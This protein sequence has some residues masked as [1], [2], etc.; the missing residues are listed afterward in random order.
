MKYVIT[1]ATSFIGIELTNY[2]IGQGYEVYAVCRK[3]S[4]HA[5]TIPNKAKIV[6]SE[7]AEYG[8][9]YDKIEAADVFVNFAW[10]GTGH[11]GRNV[12]DIQK[13]NIQN[14]IGAI[15]SAHQMGCKL[16]VEAGSQA[17]YGTVTNEITEETPCNPFSEYGKAK[18]EVKK[19]AV[20]LCKQLGMKYIHLR[21]F[22][23][24]GENDHP[25]TLVMSCINKML[26][27]EDVDLSS[28][29]QYWNFIYVKDAAKQIAALCKYA[30][31]LP[32]FQHEVYNI[33]SDDTRV[34]KEFVE[35]I[36]SQIHTSSHLNYG[37]I[38]P[39]NVVNLQPNVTKL[40]QAT[41]L[42]TF[43]PFEKV[44]PLIID[45]LHKN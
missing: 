20:V 42:T 5:K 2:L 15:Q 17:E 34:L 3:S 6:H 45:K 9:L 25:W 10:E 36:K 29:R 1:G 35:E 31:N 44:I 13:E 23:V 8:T 21:I 33:A 38:T 4:A 41:H 27:N 32:E 26:H 14:T 16:F 37:V 40:L 18:L 28:C 43:T 24:Y 12:I 39:T 11:S 22:S 7:M 30:I 19:K